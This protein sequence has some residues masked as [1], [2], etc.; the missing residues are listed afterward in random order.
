LLQFRERGDTPVTAAWDRRAESAAEA[1]LP[2][3]INLRVPEILFLEDVAS[4]G[5]G[6]LL[7]LEIRNRNDVPWNATI[8]NG[9]LLEALVLDASGTERSRQTRQLIMLSPP[10]RLDAGR[11][12]LLPLR[13]ALPDVSPRGERFTLRLRFAPGTEETESALRI[14]PRS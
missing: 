2:L 7:H 3:S 5:G 6:A 9:P 1:Y 11:G 10:T 14:A 4:A 12:F 8:P 13:I